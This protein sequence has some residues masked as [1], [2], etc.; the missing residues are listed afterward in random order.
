MQEIYLACHKW[1][2]D[3]LSPPVRAEIRD[4][5]HWVDFHDLWQWRLRIRAL[6]L[7][8]LKELHRERMATSKAYLDACNSFVRN[9]SANGPD[10]SIHWTIAAGRQE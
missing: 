5:I 2:G 7:E 10:G 3:R 6:T 1:I 9:D 4:G 8:Q